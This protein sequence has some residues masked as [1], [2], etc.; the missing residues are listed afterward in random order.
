MRVRDKPNVAPRGQ[1]D[2]PVSGNAPFRVQDGL[3]AGGRSGLICEN[4]EQVEERIYAFQWVSA[5]E[6]EPTVF[7]LCACSL[8]TLPECFATS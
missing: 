6:M 7:I 5:A 4:A 3:A 8:L 2:S 1:S